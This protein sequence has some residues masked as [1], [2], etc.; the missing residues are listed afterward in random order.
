MTWSLLY[1]EYEEDPNIYV[2]PNLKYVG[3]ELWQVNIFS[4]LNVAQAPQATKLKIFM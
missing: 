4:D 3:I 1:A 2:Y